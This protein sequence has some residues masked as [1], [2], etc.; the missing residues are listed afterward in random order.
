[1]SASKLGETMTIKC[2]ICGEIPP[3]YRILNK[4]TMCLKCVRAEYVKRF[5]ELKK[6]FSVVSNE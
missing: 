1:M 3:T 5:K 6:E 2:E 4:Q